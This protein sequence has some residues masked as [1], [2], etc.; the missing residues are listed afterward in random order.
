MKQALMLALFLS[1]LRRFDQRILLSLD[2]FL[3]TCESD[4]E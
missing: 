1:S 3:L 2:G 4:Q